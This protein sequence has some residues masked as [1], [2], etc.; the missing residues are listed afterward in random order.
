MGI[1]I[2]IGKEKWYRNIESIESTARQEASIMDATLLSKP[3][4]TALLWGHFSFKPKAKEE[5]GN[6]EEV[7]CPVGNK[8]MLVRSSNTKNL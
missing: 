3:N 5:P 2:S 1:G 8:G 4:N 7:I 6:V